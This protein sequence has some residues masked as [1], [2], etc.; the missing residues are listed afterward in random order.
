M[1][2]ISRILLTV[3]IVLPLFTSAQSVASAINLDAEALKNREALSKVKSS[4]PEL[5]SKLASDGNKNVSGEELLASGLSRTAQIVSSDNS[6][7]AARGWLESSAY[8]YLSGQMQSWLN[9]YGNSRIQIGKNTFSAELLIPLFENSNHLIFSQSRFNQAD[10]HRKMANLGLGYRHF[11]DDWMWGVNSFYDRDL[12]N[13]NA[14]LGAGLELGADYLRFST[15]GYFRLTD[16]RESKLN[17]FAGYDERPANG[18]DIRAEGFL[19]SYPNIGAN[20]QYEKYFGDNVNL[21]GSSSLSNLKDDPEAYRIGLS[22]TPVPL[23]SFKVNHAMGDVSETTGS[24][25][26]NYRFGVP[27]D[28]QL[29]SDFVSEMR[30]LKGSRYNFVDRNNSIVMQYQKQTLLRI[31]LPKTLAILATQSA[32]LMPTITQNKYKIDHIEWSAPS[33]IAKGGTLTASPLYPYIATITM[34]FYDSLSTLD[35]NNYD[36]T[37]VAV[38]ING[39][40][41]NMATTNVIVSPAPINETITKLTILPESEILANG[42]TEGVVSVVL[43]D[44]ITDKPLANMAVDFAIVNDNRAYL[45]GFKLDGNEGTTLTRMTDSEGHITFPITSTTPGDYE[46][47]VSV[48]GRELGRSNISFM[49][50][51][52]ISDEEIEIIGE[53]IVNSDEGVTVKVKIVDEDGQPVVGEKVTFTEADGTVSVAETD[54]EGFA[55]I[56]ILSP[57]PGNNDLLVRVGNSEKKVP[58]HFS[59]DRNSAQF[60]SQVLTILTEGKNKL[61][62]GLDTHEL[63]VMV[64]DRY[65]NP[66]PNYAVTFSA[67]GLTIPDAVE[68]DEEGIAKVTLT[69]KTAGVYTVNAKV[70]N[71]LNDTYD[72]NGQISFVSDNSTAHIDEGSIT[73]VPDSAIANSDE[74][75]KV[76]VKVVDKNGNVVAGEDVSFTDENGKVTTVTTDKDGNATLVVTGDK[77]GNST[78]TVEVGDS[79][80]NVDVNFKADTE[81]A[82]VGSDALTVLTQG[83]TKRA[84]GSDV[85]K[86]QVLVKDG[87]GNVVAGQKVTF[88]A[89]NGATIA[90]D[91]TTDEEGLAVV[92]VKSTT[93]GDSTIIAK[94][95][96]SKGGVSSTEGKVTFAADNSTAHIDEGSITVV[97]DSAIANSD[98]EVKVIVKVVDKNGNVVAGEDV[99][100]TDENGKVTTVTTDKDG[101]ATLVVTGDKPGNS[102]V[103]VEVGDSKVNVDVNFKADTETAAVGSDALTVLTQGETKRANGSDVHKVQ[104]LVKDGHGNVVAGQK[105]T[106]SAD[107]GA[108]IA[109]DAT[110]DEEGLAVV[111]VK[112]T[113]AG[114]STIIAKVTNSKGG[115]SSTEGKV[116]FAADNSTAHIDEGSITVVPDSAIANSDEEVKVIVKVVDK[117]GNVVAGED[118]SFTDENGK[119][120]TV[121]TDKDGNATLVVT[122]D[123][124]GNSTV[125]VEVGDSK[126]NVDVNF[127]A[128]TETAAVGSDALTVLTQGETKRANGSDVHKVQVLV[129]DGHGNVVA[130]QKVTFSADNGATIAQDATTDEEGLAVVDV[131][132]TTAGDS[133]IIAK[134]TNSKGGVSSTEGKVT[135]A[136]D[137]STAHIDEGSITVVPDSAIANSDEEV[138]VIVK[139]VDKNGNVV[140]GEDV[141]FTDE[142]GKVTT[143]T[144]DKDGN[145]TL[146]VTGDKP[147]NSTV[148][149]EVGDSKVNVDVNFKADTETAAVGSDALTVLTQGETKRANGSDVHKV[150]VL[151]KDGHGNV[152]AGQKVTFSADNGAT[153]AQD[154]TTDEEGLA[155]VDVKSTTAGDSTI[156]A[157]VTNSKGGVSSTEGK[158]TFAADNSTAHIDEGSITVVPDSAIANSDEE[159]KVIVKVVDKNGNV[160]A[161][162]DVSFTDENGKVT[163]VTTDKDGNATLVVTG[164]KPG[165]STVTVEVGDSKVNVDVNFKADTETAAVGSDALTVLTQGETKRANGSDVHKVQVLVKD[166]HGNVVAGQKVTFSADN[167]ATIA[168]DATTDEEGLAVVDVKSTTAGDST[169]IAKV[170]NSKGGVSSTE[171]KVSFVGDSETAEV[172]AKN[173]EITNNSAP[174]DGKTKLTVKVTVTDKNGNGVAGQ[175]VL[176]TATDGLTIPGTVKTDG[177]GVATVDLTSK[178]AG[179]YT[180]TAAINSGKD[181]G[182]SA[183][184]DVIFIA[185]NSTAH[186]DEGSITVVP[187]SAIANSDEEVKVIVKVVDKNGNVVAGEDV[188][189]T[190]E[191]GKVTTVTTDKD[192]NATLVVTGDKPGNSTVTVEVGDSKVNVDVNFKADTETAAVG[193]DAL[194]VLTQGETKRANGS[195]VHKV[196]VLVKDGH[197]NV[198]AGQKVT[199]SADNGATIAQ[200]ATTDEEGLAVVDV[201]STTAGDST[202][203]AKVTNSKGGVSSTEGKVTFAAD[204]ST[205]HIDEG[206]ITVVPDS[207]I[208]NSDE[209]VKVI[210]KVVDKN[211]N[212]VAGEDVSFTDENG[213]VTTVTTDKDGNAT[214]VVTGD[215]PG[216][217]TVTV[218][219]GDSKVNVDVNFKAD[220]ETAAVGSDALTVLTQGE[221]KRANG[222]DVHKVQVLVK[223]GHGNV[224]AGQKVTFSADNGATIAQDA[225]TD[226]EGLAV[227]DVKSTTAGDSTIIAK[228]TNSK[229]GVSSTEGKVTFAADNSTAHI[230]EGSITVVPDSAI[231]NSDEEVK[232]IVKVVDKNGNVVAGE[233]VSFT[234][235]NGKVTTVTTD[236]DGNATLVVTGDK[237]GNS[238]VTVEVGDSK[239]NVDVNFKADTETAAVGSDALTVLTQG[240][241]KRA[242]GS[243]VHKVQVLVKDGHGNVVAGQK[244]TFSADN[245]ATIA[246]DATTDEEGLAVVDVKSTTAGDSTI[247]AKVTNSKGGVSSTEGKVT[248]AADNSTAHIDEGSITVVPDSAIANSDEEVKVIVKV[249]DKNGNVVAGEDVSFTDENG[250]VTTV[251][252]DK[253]GNATLVVT[254]DKPGNSTVTVEV[255]DSKVNVD[256]NFKA[257]T[258]T[259][260]VGSDALTVLTQGETKRANGSDVHKVQ[261]LV[262]DGHGNVVAGQKVTF[263]AD[264]GATIAQDATTDEEGLAVVD[265]KSTTAGD[266]TII[267]KVTNSKGGVSS[268]EGK[269]TFAADNSTAHIDEGSIT[270]V[271]DSAI[272]NSDEEVKVIVKVV[273]KNGNVVAGEDVSFTDENGK[274]TTVTTDKDGN[275]TLVVTGDKP[276]NSTVT[277]EVGDSK[278]NVDVN[279][280]ADTETAA[281]GSDALT[282]LTQGET[283]RANGSDVHKV[284]VLVKD[285]HG[286]V[287]AGQKVTFS[288]DNGATIAQDATTD[289]EGLAVVDVKSTTA[290]DSTIIAKVTNSKGGVSSTEGKVTF[291]ADNSTAHIDEGSIT[292]VP[293]S[294][295]A[296]SDEEVKVIVKVVDKNGNVV[297][298]E[299]VSFTDENGKVTTVT[300]DKDG[301]ATL[302]VTG[303]KP[304][305]STVTVEVGDSKVNVDV[306]FKADTETAAV[307]SDA[308]TV[309]TQ[310]E[311]KRA[312]GSDVHKVQVLVKDGHG[313]VVAG[314]KVTFSADN[315]ATIAQDATTDE[316]GL[317]VVDVKSTTAGDSTIIAKVT[318]SKGG[319]SSTEGKVS[320]VGDSETAEVTA[321]NIEITN[322]SAPADGKTKLTVK[323]TVTDKNGN[324]VAGQDVLFTATD[325]LTIPGTVKTDGN[326]VATVD[327]TSKVAGTYTVTAAI[328]SGKDGG[329]SASKDVIF[330]A[331]N[332]TAHI[333]EGSITVV[334]DSAIANSDEEVKVIVKVV[335]KNGNV[336]AGEDVSFTDENGKVT[337]VTT[338]KDGNATLVVT[339]DKPGNSTITVEVGDSTVNVDVNFKADTETAAVGSDALTV[340][341]QGETKRA[342]GS[343]VHKVQVL[344]KDGHGNVV[345]GQKV[346]FSADN[347]ATIAQDATTDE[348]GLAVVDVKSTTAGDS[349]IIAKVTNSKGGVSSTKGKVSFVG[350]S[351]TA[352]VTA[353]NIEITNNSAPADGKTKLTVKVTVTDKNGNGVAGQDVL[354]TATDGLTIPGTVKTDANGVAT[355]DLTS[356]VAGTYTVTAAI[357]SGKN[358]GTSAS[359][360]VIFIADNNTATLT[361]GAIT[362][363]TAD[364]EKI[365]D[366]S[367]I[368]KVQVTVKDG[369]GNS[370]KGQKV[371]F[372]A[373][374]D[375]VITKEATTDE[376][377]IAIV[378]VTSKTGGDSEIVASVTNAKNVVSSAKVSVTFISNVPAV[379]TDNSSV[380]LSAD[381]IVNN[382]A[383]SGTTGGGSTVTVTLKDA[384]G[385]A[386]GGIANSIMLTSNKAGLNMPIDKNDTA[387]RLVFKETGTNT[388]I[389]TAAIKTAAVDNKSALGAHKLTLSFNNGITYTKQ[390][391][392]TVYTYQLAT[393]IANK[394]MGVTMK[395]AYSANVTASDTGAVLT[396]SLFDSIKYK[397]SSSNTAV[398]T[399][400]QDGYATA[401]ALGSVTITVASNSGKINGITPVSGTTKLSVSKLDSTPIVGDVY[402]DETTY[403][404]QPPK[405]TLPTR[406]GSIVDAIGDVGGTKGDPVTIEDTHL[407]KSISVLQCSFTVGKMTTKETFK[408]IGQIVFVYND[409]REDVK[410]GKGECDAGSKKPVQ[411][412]D[413]PNGSQLVGI[414]GWKTKKTKTT[415]GDYVSAVKFYYAKK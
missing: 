178:V 248:F 77:P 253:D 117:N 257:D 388:G 373:S 57:R 285:G 297:A 30:T 317:A 119:V 92:D 392:L 293:D 120:T 179:T 296:N 61:A 141:S 88:S 327:L 154:A 118:V 404:I 121:T 356:K 123:K 41:S 302:V 98:E 14:R 23:F 330:I 299:D 339:G 127:K 197:G 155:V 82:A 331:D 266:S 65:E 95:T 184:K 174:A 366:G 211:G 138:K 313:N 146:V 361:K 348:E 336:V 224:V 12:K 129:K 371:T 207:A 374:N 21:K 135:F 338:D 262:K 315:G 286:N 102:T 384:S 269:V 223:D 97:P 99:S 355:V 409:N 124:P 333:D 221:T 62:N 267:A 5:T 17:G 159:V 243:D 242:N 334:P 200:D 244:V 287:V 131:K 35:G 53:P 261:V 26:L 71:A 314:Q 307:G 8:G 199:F 274:V 37:A 375:A 100:F 185:D 116:T 107:N 42:E 229:G 168:Q 258:E 398:A 133:T 412:F 105:V 342:N 214:L 22:Y 139:V 166:G 79:K 225:T 222:S 54:F 379:D 369:L 156:I 27:L 357:K 304:G 108:T 66:V 122:G 247:I 167:G 194:T 278:V 382:G 415:S 236:K 9:Q 58:I 277:V 13:D 219:V 316:E 72:A 85:H 235:E 301:N 279:F 326:G 395:Y 151:V 74:E 234:D 4:L 196:Q 29:D 284:Q 268:T 180:V 239:V 161:G 6:N 96:N 52:K 212:V 227:V 109:Q 363:L 396:G 145:A 391:T 160:V 87:H 252:T 259:A 177:N 181:G 298:G 256:V 241:T 280:K 103:T 325:G 158:V 190:D 148:T 36:V 411:T 152:V 249:V 31:A 28:Q 128:D 218:E 32:T 73:V 362:V 231:A 385:K 381:R 237:P 292:V 358:G 305:N 83:E 400:A 192:G 397:W 165:N 389:Y 238:T 233:D 19:P 323:V 310:G 372:T 386:I 15:N 264:N 84:N 324:G 215:K 183:S 354:F 11:S 414:S 387:N 198:V 380:T 150:Q 376:N 149:V 106:F 209:E 113:T 201:K 367:D 350:D 89:D 283:K 125:T 220:T 93:A 202:I 263:S 295:I 271:P 94:V 273:D 265:V 112:S 187:D 328:N 408:V 349:T 63:Q 111:D 44:E 169:I 282:V 306:N 410:V 1:R 351:E 143:V 377:G 394:E 337:T 390:L 39:N 164:D 78:V 24:F 360:D 153:I 144:T 251:T 115:V 270:V 2:V 232:V 344:V 345:A 137:N 134:V 321:K 276:G 281:V 157:K 250:K 343:D 303:D 50:T 406:T 10:E 254:G 329:T 228:V 70:T 405:Y 47:S 205:A 288:A 217:S 332:S 43:K 25:E 175:D 347:G 49:T 46:L 311:T 48:D 352:E 114:D 188:S 216:N 210:V 189:F 176:F 90:Q 130:G 309:L 136:A 40:R 45:D 38:D 359:K 346:T 393:D 226:E 56:I 126:V 76:I 289:E 230:D 368:H 69:A 75:V 203:I 206:S 163:T 246:Q 172:T 173:I 399:V 413:I 335:D 275:A 34:P 204:N 80:V 193:S 18:F 312:N 182:T 7:D 290:G 260:A 16:W 364:E 300:T 110:T 213:K 51:A 132:S 308:L 340:L 101:N 104:V 170:T 140:A 186:I 60:N 33:L 401:V 142:N 191:N 255:G 272:A 291:A 240:E 378:E 383:A 20:L 3:Q 195:D 353:K 319:V 402:F 68:T 403:Y 322:N 147:G 86:V 64:I 67:D 171:G 245:G 208:A 318:N 320:F 365:A 59:V 407:V 370:V 91:A 81:T 341:T 294:A 55:H 162:E